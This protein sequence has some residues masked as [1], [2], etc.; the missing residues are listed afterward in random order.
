MN[1]YVIQIER[2]SGNGYLSTLGEPMPKR[3]QDV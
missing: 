3:K 2:W 1:F